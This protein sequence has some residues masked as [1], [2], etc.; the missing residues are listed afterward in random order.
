MS[1]SPFILSLNQL[2][3]FLFQESLNLHLKSIQSYKNCFLNANSV[4]GT[5]LKCSCSC[6]QPKTSR[7]IAIS[8]SFISQ[9][10]RALEMKLFSAKCQFG[11]EEK[12]NQTRISFAMHFNR[13]IC[14][15]ALHGRTFF[16]HLCHKHNANNSKLK[17][18]SVYL[19][20]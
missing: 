9:M 5:S 11:I 3:A 6:E 12:E 7:S 15:L 20:C 18:F 4:Q 16:L 1:G 8:L 19:T 13:F 2:D 17:F 14:L 10:K